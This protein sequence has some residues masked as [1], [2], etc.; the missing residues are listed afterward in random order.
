MIQAKVNIVEE[1]GGN[2][3]GCIIPGRTGGVEKVGF[4]GL[5]PRIEAKHL[6]GNRINT[7]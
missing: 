2:F 4:V 3:V 6:K 5:L 7:S 1:S